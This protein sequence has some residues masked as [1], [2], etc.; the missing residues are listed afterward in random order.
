MVTFVVF[1][2][3]QKSYIY[4]F[5]CIADLI[6]NSYDIY[7]TY[8]TTHIGKLINTFKNS[9]NNTWWMDCSFFHWK[10]SFF[11]QPLFKVPP[12]TKRTNYFLEFIILFICDSYSPHK[13]MLNHRNTRTFWKFL[14]VMKKQVS[15]FDN[16]T[17]SQKWNMGLRQTGRGRVH[18]DVLQK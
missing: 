6:P 18:P 3:T 10:T 8:M 12:D 4:I 15:K 17:K 5:K 7:D 14:H 2:W 13:F 16:F 9:S 1:K 11:L